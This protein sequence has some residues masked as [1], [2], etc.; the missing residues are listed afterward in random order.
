MKED[1]QNSRKKVQRGMK[2]QC[3]SYQ[4]YLVDQAKIL[5]LYGDSFETTEE[6]LI[7]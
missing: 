4:A 1:P 2:L 7:R 3:K 6:S 5:A